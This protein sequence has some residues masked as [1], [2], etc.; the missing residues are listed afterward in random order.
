MLSEAVQLALITAA[1]PTLVALATLVATLRG[2]KKISAEVNGHTEKVIQA[3]HHVGK[4]EGRVE[5]LQQA[6]T[7]ARTD[8]GRRTD[9]PPPPPPTD[10]VRY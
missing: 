1:A 10:P 3:M 6:M 9:P 5:G 2:I 4:V 7:P 8:Q